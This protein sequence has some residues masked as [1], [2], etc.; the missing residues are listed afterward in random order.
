MTQSSAAL[1]SKLQRAREQHPLGANQHYACKTISGSK[2]SAS[3]PVSPGQLPSLL[4]FCP[5][6]CLWKST[7]RSFSACMADFPL[8]AEVGTTGLRLLRKGSPKE[9]RQGGGQGTDLPG[10][11]CKNS[12]KI[13]RLFTKSRSLLPGCV[14]WNPDQLTLSR[15]V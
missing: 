10:E 6:V 8:R 5:H 9:A 11:P 14:G 15:S 12:Q 7:P 4:W 3:L 2:N 13:P 1:P